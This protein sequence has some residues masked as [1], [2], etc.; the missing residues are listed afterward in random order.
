MPNITRNAKYIHY[1]KLNTGLFIRVLN[2]T[3]LM[4]IH[5]HEQSKDRAM[6]YQ[7]M[8]SAYYRVALVRDISKWR[9]FEFQDR[10]QG[11][12]I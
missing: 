9:L 12:S 2:R 4:Y 3:G 8:P 11:V 5:L 7:C 6:V 1:A 10:D